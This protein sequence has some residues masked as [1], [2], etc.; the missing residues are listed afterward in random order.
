MTL[1]REK[2]FR[3]RRGSGPAVALMFTPADTFTFDICVCINHIYL[4]LII[5][6]VTHLIFSLELIPVGQ[7]LL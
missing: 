1:S 3:L 4:I 2:R 5:F 6:L 7:G